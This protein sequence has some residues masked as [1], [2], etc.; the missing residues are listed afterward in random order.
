MRNALR[1]SFGVGVSVAALWL[2]FHNVDLGET[3]RLVTGVRGSYVVLALACGAIIQ[4]CRVVR[5]GLLVQPLA[6]LSVGGMMRVGNPGLLLVALLPLRLGELARPILLKRET[7]APLSAG[8]GAAA[9][10]RTIDGLLVTGLFYL[11]GALL[12]Q[13]YVLT[14]VLELAALLA[15]VLFAGATVVIV[16]GVLARA[17]TLRLLRRLGDRFSPG[18]TDRMMSLLQA[19][20]EG[21]ATLRSARAMVWFGF[22]TF[23]YWGFNAASLYCFCLAFGWTLPPIAGVLLVCVLVLG[24]MIPAGPAFLGTFQAALVAGLQVFDV[25]PAGAAAYSVLVY[26][27]TMLTLLGFGLP[28]LLAGRVTLKELNPAPG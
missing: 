21:L 19:F 10:E 17:P 7:G 9:V 23:L 16:G 26:V 5:Y 22:L 28:Y 24:V 1:L 27:T 18:A 12:P 13:P 3:W 15:L 2:A 6:P 25:D 11:T 20:I 4:V 8:L 14:A